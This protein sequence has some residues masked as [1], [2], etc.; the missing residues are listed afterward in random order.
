MIGPAM[1]DN[2]SEQHLVIAEAEAV[3]TFVVAALV[4]MLYVVA[5][6]RQRRR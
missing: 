3:L 5:V 6:V 1:N 2:L 4:G